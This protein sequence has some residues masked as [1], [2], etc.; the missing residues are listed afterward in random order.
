MSDGIKIEIRCEVELKL[1]DSFNY[2]VIYWVQ[3]VL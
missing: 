2:G 3:N 1:D